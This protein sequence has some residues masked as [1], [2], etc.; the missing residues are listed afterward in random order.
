[1]RGNAST[2]PSNVIRRL[3]LSRGQ[4]AIPDDPTWS[5]PCTTAPST[6]SNLQR[7]TPASTGIGALRHF[8]SGPVVAG[9]TLRSDRLTPRLLSAV[10]NNRVSPCSDQADNPEGIPRRLSTWSTSS[11]SGDS[12]TRRSL[13]TTTTRSRACITPTNRGQ[14][15]TDASPRRRRPSTT[16]RIFPATTVPG[17][18][19]GSPSGHCRTA[20]GLPE[21]FNALGDSSTPSSANTN[22][23][24]A[25]T[26]T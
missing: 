2:V 9:C 1:M 25:A 24:T 23:T 21:P 12:T 26:P 18:I 14:L 5:R 10:F 4:Y 19:P 13:Q 6:G 20:S 8:T 16:C 15:A 22:R 7:L 11:P 3:R 17:L